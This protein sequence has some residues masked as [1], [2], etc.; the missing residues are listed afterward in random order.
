MSED[1]ASNVGRDSASAGRS[2]ERASQSV[3]SRFTRIMNATLSPWGALTD[4]AIVGVVTAPLIIALVITARVEA[5]P[6]VFRAIAALA[7]LPVA[8]ALV[9]T[10]ALR[11]KRAELVAWLAR[12]P[13][14]I[15]NMNA[16]LNGIGE[17]LEVVFEDA[18]PTSQ[19]LNRAIDGVSAE[20]FVTRSPADEKGEPG[21]FEIRIGV[22][23]ST[24]NPSASNHR[25][26]VRVR[27]LVER[28]FGP[29]AVKYPIR[30]IRIK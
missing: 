8:I 11:G 28:A 15:E 25:R 23:D 16:V 17:S 6:T 14:P 3:A 12:Q 4:P 19:E 29:M 27:D 2:I 1:S 13:F 21:V 26:F 18:S 10:I 24:R 30:E 5:P 22:V 7:A 20:S 9:A